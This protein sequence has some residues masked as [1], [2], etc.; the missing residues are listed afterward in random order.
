MS[1]LVCVGWALNTF[2]NFGCWMESEDV[3]RLLVI[4]QEGVSVGKNLFCYSKRFKLA[5]KLV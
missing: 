4:C 5:K 1:G 2:S 3:L